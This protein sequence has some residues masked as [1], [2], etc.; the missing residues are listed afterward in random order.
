MR[1]NA[2]RRG[3][4]FRRRL[5]GWRRCATAL[6]V[7]RSGVATADRTCMAIATTVCRPAD[8]PQRRIAGCTA[9]A[10]RCAV[11]RRRRSSRSGVVS[12]VAADRKTVSCSVAAHRAA[13]ASHV[14]GT[15]DA[16]TA[17]DSGFGATREPAGTGRAAHGAAGSARRPVRR[18]YENALSAVAELDRERVRSRAVETRP[19][20][21]RQ[22][23]VEHAGNLVRVFVD[24]RLFPVRCRRCLPR[25]S[26]GP[27]RM[28]E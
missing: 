21:F 10:I 1:S 3:V 8:A 16:I 17:P 20:L 24:R 7:L 27:M 19:L 9:S 26:T 11:R 25:N 28:V 18:L 6:T 14:A 15:G 23:G 4:V 13:F 2:S 22:A 12:S 5:P